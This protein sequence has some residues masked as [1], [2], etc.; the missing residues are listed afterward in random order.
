MRKEKQKARD[1]STQN[2]RRSKVSYQGIPNNQK[3]TTS[4]KNRPFNKELSSE[5]FHKVNP[6]YP[7]LPICTLPLQ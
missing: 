5:E 2:Y 3:K 1:L 7:K 4:D 6:L